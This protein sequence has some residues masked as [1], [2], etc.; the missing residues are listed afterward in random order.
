MMQFQECTVI[1]VE[2]P[3]IIEGLVKDYLLQEEDKG[4]PFPRVVSTAFCHSLQILLMKTRRQVHRCKLPT[5]RVQHR[6]PKGKKGF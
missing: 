5:H 6:G 4:L 1:R 3:V 2:A